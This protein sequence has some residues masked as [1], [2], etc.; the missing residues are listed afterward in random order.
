MHAFL[1]HP[2]QW[3]LFR[4]GRPRTAADEIVRW[5][6][7]VTSFQRTATHDTELGGAKIR[8]GDRVGIFYASANHDPQVF[9]SPDTFDIPR[10]PNAH[11][12]SVVAAP[13]SASTP[14]SPA[15]RLAA[16]P[17]RLRS[18]WLNGVQELRVT[19]T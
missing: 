15:I 13:T 7:P 8:E 2:E 18:T 3:D 1:T 10:D 4:A 17:R 9:T 14:A 19:Y 12:V 11:L 5:P 6:T 16:E